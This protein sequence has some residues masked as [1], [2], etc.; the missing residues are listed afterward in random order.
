MTWPPGYAIVE[1]AAGRRPRQDDRRAR[2]WKTFAARFPGDMRPWLRRRR[3]ARSTRWSE[4]ST[5]LRRFS[6]GVHPP[7][8]GRLLAVYCDFEDV[9]KYKEAVVAAR[10]AGSPIG[11]ATVRIIKPS[12]AGLLRQVAECEPEL[13][14]IRNLAGLSHYLGSIRRRSR[15]DRGL[16]AERGQRGDGSAV[17]GARRPPHHAQLRPELEATDGVN[18]SRFPV[19]AALS[20]R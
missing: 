13:I 16:F 15:T 9:R 5:S 14:L 2:C 3:I 11:L 10:A 6:R 4:H 7:T 20:R 12:E 18:G 19:R 17:G 1:R 8:A